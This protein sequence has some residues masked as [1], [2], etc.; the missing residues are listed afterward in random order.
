[1]SD[2]APKKRRTFC[3]P[4]LSYV[5]EGTTDDAEE[6]VYLV[7]ERLAGNSV[8]V[9]VCER[10]YAAYVRLRA[11]YGLEPGAP[12]EIPECVS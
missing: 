12:V 2:L 11:R 9:P 5:N 8:Y 7:R 4:C 3:D 6:A 10:H 1:M